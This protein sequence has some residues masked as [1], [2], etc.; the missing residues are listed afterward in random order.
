MTIAVFELIIK[1][2]EYWRFFCVSLQQWDRS[3]C[4]LAAF[5]ASM[6]FQVP[7]MCLRSRELRAA[8]GSGFTAVLKSQNVT[9]AVRSRTV[10]DSETHLQ[11][12]STRLTPSRLCYNLT[13]SIFRIE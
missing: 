13:T 8:L 2:P 5:H 4:L 3:C 6:V 1:A 7:A 10:L 11:G 9:N 12:T